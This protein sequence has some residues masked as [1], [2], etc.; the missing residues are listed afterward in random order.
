MRTFALA[1]LSCLGLS[2]S[3]TPRFAPAEKSSVE[4]TIR[5]ELEFAVNE[6]GMTMDGRELPKSMTED[7]VLKFERKAKLVLTDRYVKSGAGRPLELD[8]T[9]DEITETKRD[10]QK[11]P[12]QTEER[13]EEKTR[14]S[15]LE[16]KTVRFS[17]KADS[18]SYDKKFAGEDGDAEL[19]AG[20]EEDVDFR[21]LLPKDGAKVGDTWEVDGK[22]LDHLLDSC[23][24]LHLRDEGGKPEDENDD[25]SRQMDE[26]MTGTLEVKFKEVREKD[27]LRLAVLKLQGKLKSHAQME[28][29]TIHADANLEPEGELLWDLDANRLH[30]LDVEGKIGV[31]M[32][33][34][35]KLGQDG[36][37]EH[38]LHLDL[39]FE[40]RFSVEVSTK[41]P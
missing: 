5:S 8:R 20:L 30:A 31:A 26:N 38:V 34:D 12:G 33:G 11:M 18:E 14:A 24:N 6:F 27:G 22:R 1:I 13:V 25:F 16:S 40:G 9:F 32:V 17:W 23:G 10:T 41:T 28:K 29:E 4:K 7:V 39:R 3:D 19:L 15:A 21:A 2:V 35:Q 36:N 37:G